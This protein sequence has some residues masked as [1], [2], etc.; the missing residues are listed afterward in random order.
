MNA[1]RTLR[2]HLSHGLNGPCGPKGWRSP[3]QRVWVPLA[4]RAVRRCR[5][6]PRAFEVVAPAITVVSRPPV[7][8]G[9]CGRLKFR[10]RGRY[11]ALVSRKPGRPFQATPFSNSTK[12]HE[13]GRFPRRPFTEISCL[14]IHRAPLIV[15][16][17]YYQ[18]NHS[19]GSARFGDSCLS[20]AQT[21]NGRK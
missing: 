2:R 12:N 16:Y 14:G 19:L 10:L 4:M 15:V 1:L 17:Y 18:D 13:I 9:F 20:H 8:W 11:T 5:Y 3:L 6:T 7:M 21:D